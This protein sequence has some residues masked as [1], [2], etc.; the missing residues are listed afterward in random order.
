MITVKSF[1]FN[2]FSVNTYIVHDSTREAVII[3]C[4]CVSPQEDDVVKNYIDE[5]H[6]TLKHNLCTHLHL[7]HILGNAFIYKT[8]GVSPKAHK[9]DINAL[10]SAK[11]QARMFGLS[12]RIVSVTVEKYLIGGE[13]ITFGHSVLTTLLIPGHSPGSLSF[14]NKEKGY[15]FSGDTLFAGSIGR[16]DLWGGNMEVL[17]AAIHDKLLTLPDET[18]VYPGHGQD[19]TIFAEKRDNPFL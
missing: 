13:N 15:L 5:N 10:P 11:E 14:Y 6:L 7:D 19:T 4:G 17:I 2:Y 18:I 8:Y 1:P 9:A 16:T 12:P 3:D